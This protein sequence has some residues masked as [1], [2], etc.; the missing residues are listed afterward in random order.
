MLWERRPPARPVK[1]LNPRKQ[2]LRR[3]IRNNNRKPRGRP[4]RMS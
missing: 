1:A 2:W 3:K 4:D